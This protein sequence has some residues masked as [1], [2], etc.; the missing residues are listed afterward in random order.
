M[1][2]A[3]FLLFP[4]LFFTLEPPS[5]TFPVCDV[6]PA[7]DLLEEVSYQK[8]ANFFVDL[9]T[10]DEFWT[11]EKREKPKARLEAYA[12]ED[13]GLI[14]G[15]GQHPL[16]LAIQM[17][18][19]EHRPL[20]LSPDDMWLLILQGFATHVDLN[21]EALRDHFV[22][23]EGRK[24]LYIQR[25]DYVRGDSLFPWPEVFSAFGDQIS[26]HT[27]TDLAAMAR[28]R[29]STTGP[30]E[31]A[32]FEVALMDA[33]STYFMYVMSVSCGIPEIT[34]EGTPED[35]EALEERTA[36][37]GQFELSWWTDR[38]APILK[39]F[40]AASKGQ[41]DKTFWQDIFQLRS[42][43]IVCGTVPFIT[44]WILQFFPYYEDVPNPWVT[45]PVAVDSF[46]QAVDKAMEKADGSSWFS[47][48]KSTPAETIDYVVPLPGSYGLP[49]LDLSVLPLGISGADLLV[50]YNGTQLAYELKAGFVGV[51]QDHNTFALSPEISWLI[52]DTG[53]APAEE[54]SA[55]YEKWKV[56]QAKGG[57]KE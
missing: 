28:E 30:V 41:V 23:H 12:R 49:A 44:G 36:Y 57:G 50:D 43:N 40:T 16:V 33:M 11:G 53:E 26:Q 38:L 7:T 15:H 54:D 8:V 14:S 32:A 24:V 18:Y 1:L 22:S 34:L 3:I 10:E 46:F 56:E 6:V 39:E 20:S 52:I 35:W 37:L 47:R 42:G 9:G 45:N 21:G 29:F 31:Q 27:N 25:D 2:N 19:A 4:F 55:L 48:E 13:Y 51:R 17:A 5:T